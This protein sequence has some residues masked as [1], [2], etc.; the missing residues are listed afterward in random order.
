MNTYDV[1]YEIQENGEW[2]K[3]NT[4]FT[5]DERIEFE[6][7]IAR[8]SRVRNYNWTPKECDCVCDGSC[9]ENEE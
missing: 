3:V 8:G 9:A 6:Q 7:K 2:R 5:L 1:V 4:V